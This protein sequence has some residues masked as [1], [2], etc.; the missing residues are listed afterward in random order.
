MAAMLLKD[1]VEYCRKSIAI[2]FEAQLVL[3]E[4][5]IIHVQLEISPAALAK[6][7]AWVELWQRLSADGQNQP[8]RVE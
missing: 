4:Q 2:D 7:P 3:E 8:G 6:L 5:E 1:F